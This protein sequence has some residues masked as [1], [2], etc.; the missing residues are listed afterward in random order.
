MLAHRDKKRR[1]DVDDEFM[2]ES[3]IRMRFVRKRELARCWQ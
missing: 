3:A 1:I 2:T